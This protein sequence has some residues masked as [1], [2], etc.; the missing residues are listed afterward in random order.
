M[1]PGAWQSL[2]LM[3]SIYRQTRFL[4]SVYHPGRLPLDTGAEAAFA[5]RSNA[6]K[7]SVIN[8]LCQQKRLAQVSKMPGRTRMLNFFTIDDARRLVDL[9]GYGYAQAPETMRRHWRLLVEHYLC[10]RRS[11]RGLIL[12]MD[13]RH[14]LNHGD[15][16]LLAWCA[17]RNLRMHILLT[18]ADKLSRGAA[19][20]TVR[21]VENKLR[22]RAIDTSLQPFSALKRQGLD[23]TY[24]VLDAWLDLSGPPYQG[25]QR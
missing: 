11:L 2:L 10:Q 18:K 19:I 15:W 20:T 3:D 8:A 16:Q 21:R 23:E 14:P 13:I 5:G 17:Q 7:S 6:G 1:R 9:P 12:V 25:D 4:T 24:R 22:S